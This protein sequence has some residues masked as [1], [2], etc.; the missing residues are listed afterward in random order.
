MLDNLQGLIGVAA[1][2]LIALALGEARRESLSKAGVRLVVV[3]LSLQVGL[4][5]VLLHAP[6]VKDG[7]AALNSVVIALQKAT[8]VGTSFVFGYL[9]GGKLPFAESFPGSSFVLAF[10][11][12]PLILVLSALSAVLF[13]WGV[14]QFVVR[15]FS[16]ALER[17]LRI[18]GAL[19]VGAAVNVF[20]GMVE[21]PILVRPYV[22]I[23]SRG[24]LFALMT[25][26]MATI[27]G[28]VMILYASFLAPVMPGA[29]GHILSASIMNVPGAL[30][31]AA[32]M[33]P[34]AGQ[35]TGGGFDPERRTKS[36]MDAVASGTAD[37]V[38]LLINVIAMLVV[39]VALVAL[40]NL[41]LGL[42]P[43]VGGNPLSLQRMFGWLLSPLAWSLGIPWEEAKT[44]GALLGTKVVL[45]ELIAYLELAK[46]PADA[47]SE[48]SRLILV[49]AVCGFANLGSLG[50]MI[51]GL[52]ALVPERRDDIV[53]LGFRSV[54]SGLLAT[55]LS[56]AI[57]GLIM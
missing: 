31:I 23:M 2:L 39:L 21:S 8:T 6:L 43:D 10:Q 46:L 57:V 24:E 30:V 33:V 3:G 38:Q 41:G 34:L 7:L 19:G 16:W 1:I 27:A 37:G 42:L 56:G 9:G 40:I 12:L 45:N 22:R 11:A 28:T 53:N 4:G 32:L 5:L 20:V 52:A 35:A 25:A 48:K 44:G 13:H 50:I 14:L 49:Y 51:G 29:L 26:G 54:I 15:G 36:T 17:T 18:G 47:L 55:C